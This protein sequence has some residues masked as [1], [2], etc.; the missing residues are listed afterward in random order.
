MSSPRQCL[1]IRSLAEFDSLVNQLREAPVT[2]SG[3]APIRGLF[4]ASAYQE[5]PDRQ[6]RITIPLALHSYAGST[7]TVR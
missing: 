6:G 3:R 7:A 4:F 5:T 1:C 2:H